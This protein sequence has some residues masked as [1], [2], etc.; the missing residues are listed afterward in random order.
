MIPC[1]SFHPPRYTA[2]AHQFAVPFAVPNTRQ[3]APPVTT[4]YA[5]VTNTIIETVRSTA[6][7]SS[8]RIA[9]TGTAKLVS[10]VP[11]AL[12]DD[13]TDAYIA[14]YKQ[15]FGVCT[16]ANAPIA[17]ACAIGICAV[18]KATTRYIRNNPPAP[19]GLNERAWKLI[20]K[21]AYSFLYK[22]LAADPGMRQEL[23]KC[24]KPDNGE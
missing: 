19:P 11:K 8:T 16:K 13:T 15:T 20:M 10:R 2:L 23:E 9:G 24:E 5:T 18:G 4:K 14:A 17:I 1:G 6:A 22:K 21:H 3:L 7:N 12:L